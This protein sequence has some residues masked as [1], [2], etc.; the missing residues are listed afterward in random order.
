MHPDTGLMLE[1]TRKA[2]TRAKAFGSTV[3]YREDATYELER[4]EPAR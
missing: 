3:D 2:D 1:S 4:L